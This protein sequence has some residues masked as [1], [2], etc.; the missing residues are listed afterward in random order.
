MSARPRYKGCT[1]FFEDDFGRQSMTRLVLFLCTI[2]AIFVAIWTTVHDKPNGGIELI[3]TLLSI[4]TIGKSVKGLYEQKEKEIVETN[5][6]IAAE[7]SQ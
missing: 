6:A 1:E 3:A 4:P 5:Q 7:N 2:A